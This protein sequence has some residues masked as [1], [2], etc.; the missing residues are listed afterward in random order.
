MTLRIEGQPNWKVTTPRRSRRAPATS[1][2]PD[3]LRDGTFEIVEEATLTGPVPPPI[4]PARRGARATRAAGPQLKVQLDQPADQPCVV[5]ARQESGAIS[6]HFPQ[7]GTKPGVRGRRARAATT[8]GPL[9]VTIPIGGGTPAKEP[10]AAQRQRGTRGLADRVVKVVVLKVAN[11]VADYAMEVLGRQLEE[12]LWQQAQRREGWVRVVLGADGAVT[13]RPGVPSGDVSGRALVLL[14][15]T[16]SHTAAAFADL[17]SDPETATRLKAL[18]GDRIYGYDHF[19]ISKTPGENVAEL[20]AALPAA[21]RCTCDVITHS[22]GGLVLRTLHQELT[23]GSRP[24]PRLTLGRVVLVASPNGGTP[25]A[26]PERWEQTLGWFANLLEMFP[27]NAFTTAAGWISGSLSWLAQKLNRNLPGIES[28]DAGG[29]TIRDLAKVPGAPG[30]EWSAV[31]ADTAPPVDKGLAAR[32]ADMGVDRFFQEANDLVVPTEGGRQWQGASLAKIPDERVGRFARPGGNLQAP[33]DAFVM[34]TTLFAQA[35]TRKFIADTLQTPTVTAAIRAALPPSQLPTLFPVVPVESQR[36]DPMVTW[37]DPTGGRSPVVS[38]APPI[39]S[40]PGA[41]PPV[42]IRNE[43]DEQGWSRQDA[44]QLIVLEAPREPVPGDDAQSEDSEVTDSK[45]PKKGKFRRD[46]QLLAMYGGASVL[47]PF[48]LGGATN[49]S[50]AHWQKIIGRHKS[51]TKY[52]NDPDN[53]PAPT[54]E[55]VREMGSHMFQLM[56]P[57]AV[58]LLYDQAR[59]RERS[60]KLNVVFTSMIP[61]V[62]DLPWEFAFDDSLKEFLAVTDVRFVRGVLTG[63]ASD[64]IEAR[65]ASPLRILLVTAQPSDQLQLDLSVEIARIHDVLKELQNLQLVNITVLS[66]ATADSLHAIVR[67]A[68]YGEFDVVHFMGHGDFEESTD[69]GYLLFNSDNGTTHKMST[70]HL[71]AILR[72]RGVKIV[73]LNACQT[74]QGGHIDYNKGV[75]PGL[76]AGGVPAVVANQYSVFDNAATDFAR[77]FYA[78][79]AQGLTL[80]DAAREARIELR[81]GLPEPSEIS[82]GVPVLFTRNPDAVLCSRR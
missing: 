66:N 73:F 54:A 32:L 2:L 72:G 44:L 3:C 74:G 15:G 77:V 57:P 35:A 8:T 1:P 34:H 24:D 61:W 52:M 82:W 9:T 71:C 67:Q 20:L 68:R 70:E 59:Y 6:F 48:F 58:R 51:L 79:L 81:F 53:N 21:L 5:V 11:A 55:K 12:R 46:A 62:A 50:G 65:V 76:V 37:A 78:C 80:G 47:V 29:A 28:M 7:A 31:V 49:D 42:G 26:T 39:I 40:T 63:L 22:R 64:R 18:Y 56:F 36:A 43:A 69:T 27:D 30:A 25:L 10:T 4:R 41:K 19:T 45:P 23:K 13:C 33:A 17:L 16:F 75:A 60:R 38:D 14:H